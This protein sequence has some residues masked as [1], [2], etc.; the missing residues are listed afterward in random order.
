[1]PEDLQTAVVRH[2]KRQGPSTLTQI[3][4]ALGKTNVTVRQHLARLEQM[5]AI[6][7]SP[8]RHAQGPGR[9]EKV[10]RLTPKAA[11][12]LPGND[13][14][15]AGELARQI[16]RALPESG[17]STLFH[18]SGMR[19]AGKISQG[20]PAASDSRRHMA[21]E[22]LEQRG[23]FPSWEADEGALR[24]QLKSC[25]Y[26]SAADGC[27]TLCAFDTGLLSGL[28]GCDVSVHRSIA[29]GDPTCAFSLAVDSPSAFRI[30]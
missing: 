6:E 28:M 11:P 10:Y 19:L 4:L 27:P 1:M 18:D 21:L 24:L 17:A 30:K 12:L 2:L 9:P 29:R 26:G 3:G 5:G 23:Y 15:L 16:Q 14:E 7:D 25:P 13:R 22:A 8:R 20:W